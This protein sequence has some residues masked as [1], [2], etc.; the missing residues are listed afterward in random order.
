M[1][2]IVKN[3]LSKHKPQ[4]T[5]IVCRQKFDKNELN[6]ITIDKESNVAINDA[7][8]QGRSAYVCKNDNCLALCKN[9]NIL[10]KKLKVEIKQEIYDSLTNIS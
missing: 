9:K 5:C 7:K 10:S 4:R 2:K 1:K 8:A 3:N 6:K